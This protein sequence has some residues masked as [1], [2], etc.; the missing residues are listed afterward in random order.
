MKMKQRMFEKSL[1]AVLLK[2]KQEIVEESSGDEHD[3]TY[4]P[5]HWSLDNTY[6]ELKLIN[7]FCD[8]T[9]YEEVI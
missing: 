2:A 5:V 7:S 3:D 6:E 9:V 4:V 1:K 8:V